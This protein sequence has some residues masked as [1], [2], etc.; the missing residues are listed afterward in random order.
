[1]SWSVGNARAVYRKKAELWSRSKLKTYPAVQASCNIWHATHPKQNTNWIVLL[2]DHFWFPSALGLCIVHLSCFSCI[3]SYQP[4]PYSLCQIMYP[5]LSVFKQVIIFHLP[6][7]FIASCSLLLKHIPTPPLTLLQQPSTL[8]YIRW[9]SPQSNGHYSTTLYS[10]HYSSHILDKDTEVQKVSLAAWSHVTSKWLAELKF[11]SS[12]NS[13]LDSLHLTKLA[14]TLLSDTPVK[15]ASMSH[16]FRL[17]ISLLLKTTENDGITDYGL[18]PSHNTRPKPRTVKE[19]MKSFKTLPTWPYDTFC[20]VV[21][22]YVILQMK[23][24][25]AK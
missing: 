2:W 15:K 17:T 18:G 4:P 20:Q 9:P 1:M 25:R 23:A 21:C 7:S 11:K 10:T 14:L 6:Q 3:L 19:C 12:C 5:H 22:P 13:S 8:S 24:T 16:P